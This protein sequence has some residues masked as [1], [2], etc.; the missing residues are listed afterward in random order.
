MMQQIMPGKSSSSWT[1]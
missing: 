1:K